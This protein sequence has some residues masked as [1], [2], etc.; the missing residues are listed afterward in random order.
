MEPPKKLPLL[1]LLILSSLT[2][3]ATADARAHTISTYCTTTLEHN[4]TAFVTNFIGEVNRIAEQMQLNGYGLAVL[5]V[6]PDMA[7][8]LAQ[9]YGDLSL[10]DCVLCYTEAHTVLSKC[11]PSNGGRIYLDGCFMRSDSYNFFDEFTGPH[12]KAVCGNATTAQDGVR[13]T[14]LVKQAVSSAVAAAPLSRGY[15]RDSA[16]AQGESAYVLANCWRTINQSDCAACLSNAS[17]AALGCLPGSEGRALYTGCFLRYSNT[18]FL[19]AIPGSGH[20][21]GKIIAIVVA[22]VSAVA[23]VAVGLAVGNAIRKNRIIQ[24]KRKDVTT[25][26]LMPITYHRFSIHCYN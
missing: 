26:P 4:S 22:I 14:T 18:D 19:N 24:K 21:K 16:T 23:L 7:Y 5:G 6:S 8:G 10:F 11:Y 25:M 1:L 15:A 13:F 9:C 3:L 20:S 17:K 12:D 2:P